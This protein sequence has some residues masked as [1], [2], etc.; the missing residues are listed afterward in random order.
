MQLSP[1]RKGQRVGM[2]RDVTREETFNLKTK[3]CPEA[4]TARAKEN[5]N[6]RHK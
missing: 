6:A 1:N 5:R 2:L 3:K 4:E